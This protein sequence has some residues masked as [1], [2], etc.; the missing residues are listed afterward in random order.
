MAGAPALER[1][2]ASKSAWH[3]SRPKAPAGILQ[4][5]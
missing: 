5:K 3:L 4:V 1:L 2:I